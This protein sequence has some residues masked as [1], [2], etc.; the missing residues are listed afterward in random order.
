MKNPFTILSTLMLPLFCGQ[1]YAQNDKKMSDYKL[2]CEKE[3]MMISQS[4]MERFGNIT[5]D[6]NNNK[7]IVKR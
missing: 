1:A 2:Q 7:L 3:T 5:I 6:N 4:T